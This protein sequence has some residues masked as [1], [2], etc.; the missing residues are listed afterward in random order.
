MPREMTKKISILVL[1]IEGLYF[2]SWWNRLLTRP[3]KERDYVKD[4]H[5]QQPWLQ[6]RIYE[7]V[8]AIEF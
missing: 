1:L 5:F 7:H 8:K 2:A 3:K 4:I 6:G